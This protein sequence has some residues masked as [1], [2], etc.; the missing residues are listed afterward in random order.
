MK[1]ASVLVVEDDESLRL[2]LV[3]NLEQEGYLVKSADT[4]P[5]AL[6]AAQ[7]EAFDLVILDIMLP[8]MDGYTV[9]RKLREAGWAG[10]IM[11]LTARSLEDDLVKGFEAGADD[12]LCKP[13]RLRELLMRTRALLRRSDS[14]GPAGAMTFAGYRI[15]TLSRAVYTPGGQP[16][17]LTR[18]EFD[19]LLCL[20]QFKNQALTRDR[21]LDQVWGQDVV[22]DGR[23]VD[24]FVSSLKRKLGW[25]AES[26][27]AITSIR[28]VG[29]RFEVFEE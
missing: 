22:V 3:D 7:A 5:G 8:Q 21:I 26:G 11:M 28:G 14:A 16:V 24:N 4:G 25:G 10:M 17:E 27:F 19:L 6:E 29:Y 9:C 20:L 2:A 15:D 23:T 1:K 13:Y 12:Y 18:T